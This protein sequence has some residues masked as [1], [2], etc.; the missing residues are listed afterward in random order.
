MASINATSVEIFSALERQ[1]PK[2]EFKRPS[3]AEFYPKLMEL[4]RTSHE[5]YTLVLSTE[6]VAAGSMLFYSPRH[7]MPEKPAH[8]IAVR[9]HARD[10]ERAEIQRS[11]DDIEEQ[12]SHSRSEITRI[13][14]KNTQLADALVVR[15]QQLLTESEEYQRQKRE[16]DDKAAELERQAQ[17]EKDLSMQSENRV[18]HTHDKI[19]SLVEKETSIRES[20]PVLTTPL[21]KKYDRLQQQKQKLVSVF[22]QLDQPLMQPEPHLI[23]LP[24]P[25][26]IS[27][28]PDSAETLLNTDVLESF[29]IPI[30]PLANLIDAY[31]SLSP[32]QRDM[33]SNP[34]QCAAFT[35]WASGSGNA[36]STAKRPRCYE[37]CDL[38]SDE[39]TAAESSPP[40]PRPKK[41]RVYSHSP[42]SPS[43]DA[44][45]IH[46]EE[47]RHFSSSPPEVD[48]HCASPLPFDPSMLPPAFSQIINALQLQKDK[49]DQ[50]S[51]SLRRTF[52]EFINPEQIETEET[53]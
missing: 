21:H 8:Q 13:E 37:E 5:W 6:M 51:L 50:D 16:A 36:P 53:E 4:V 52:D 42:R 7:V 22:Y 34:S 11:L 2:N 45:P 27:S 20:I 10:E 26:N 17:V 38:D 3:A 23:P 43:A 44:S 18:I 33:F 40:H 12:S 30:R 31:L 39:E 19:K 35:E 46:R 28:R 25:L 32:P 9:S 14:K 15:T 41:A 29:S 48:H 24:N 1:F 47:P 49:A